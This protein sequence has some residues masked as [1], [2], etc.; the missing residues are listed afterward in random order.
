MK[1]K[2]FFSI[3][4]IMM[5]MMAG[6]LEE[7]GD[8][9]G[10]PDSLEKDGWKILVTYQGQEKKWIHVT[11]DSH[12]KDTDGDGLN[13]Y[14]EYM[15][16]IGGYSTNPRKEDTDGDGLTDYDEINGTRGY[17]TDPTKWDTDRDGLR[18]GDEILYSC[19]PFDRDTDEDYFL[20]GREAA[21]WKEL[22]FDEHNIS[23]F[24][25]NRDVDG[26][27]LLDGE[28]ADPLQKNM[29]ICLQLNSINVSY[30]GWIDFRIWVDDNENMKSENTRVTKNMEKNLSSSKYKFYFDLDDKLSNKPGTPVHWITIMVEYGYNKYLR[31][32]GNDWSYVNDDFSIPDGCKE[33]CTSGKDG[34]LSFTITDA[35][36]R[37]YG[38]VHF[39]PKY[40]NLSI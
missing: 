38:F 29:R 2:I 22:E 37:P 12:K 11:S 23:D 35:S 4:L 19:D 17:F 16:S 26:D 31:I 13:D 24:L 25:N 27:G 20:D 1:K 6:C 28:D 30:T 36:T 18:D 33:Y 5:S 15:T 7:D 8:G 14:D 32:D 3:F 9:D 21:F 39:P 10:L 34:I 40:G